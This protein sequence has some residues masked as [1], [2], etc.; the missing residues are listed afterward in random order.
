MKHEKNGLPMGWM[1]LS[2]AV[3]FVQTDTI[4]NGIDS[5]GDGIPDG[6]ERKYT[7]DTTTL[8]D[9]GDLDGDGYNDL[10]E[11]EADSDPSDPTDN[12]RIV[13]L[14]GNMDGSESTLT[15]RSTLTRHYFIQSKLNIDSDPWVDHPT[16]VV[17]PDLGMT[18]TRTVTDEAATKRFFRIQAKRPLSP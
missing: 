13:F 7:G 8:S 5:D 3:A 2:N 1:S 16:G 18:T 15:W 17:M 11:Y 6:W 14:D 12:L 4:T 10:D 9:V